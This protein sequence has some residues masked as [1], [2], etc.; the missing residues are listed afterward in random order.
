MPRFGRNANASPGE[1][2]FLLFSVGSEKG[3]NKMRGVIKG[4]AVAWCCWVSSSI[5]YIV[6]FLSSISQP[7]SR[8]VE[9]QKTEPVTPHVAA[10]PGSVTKGKTMNNNKIAKKRFL[11]SEKGGHY[12]YGEDYADGWNEKG[13]HVYSARRSGAGNWVVPS[14]FKAEAPFDS[15][16]VFGDET[17]RAQLKQKRDVAAE[18]KAAEETGKKA[19]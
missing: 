11:E 16:Y 2:I 12:E 5:V 19:K 13:A 6:I 1:R 4:L 15:D 9:K 8:L 10:F 18:E 3:S 17:A 7:V 14:D